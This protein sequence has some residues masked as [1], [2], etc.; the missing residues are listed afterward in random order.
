MEFVGAREAPQFRLPAASSVS[1][2][3]FTNASCTIL[4]FF[5]N[6]GREF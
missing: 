2:S 1:S 4:V 3:D 5:D 6:V